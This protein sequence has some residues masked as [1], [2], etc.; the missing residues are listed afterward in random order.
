MLGPLPDTPQGHHKAMM[1]HLESAA[2][3][4]ERLGAHVW[5]LLAKIDALE[6]EVKARGE[7]IAGLE[8][9]VDEAQRVL[10]AVIYYGNGGRFAISEEALLDDYSVEHTRDVAMMKVRLRAW[11]TDRHEA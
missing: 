11:P 9:Q 4:A 6:S 10:G 3:F 8:R 2:L 1:G 7:T 5:S